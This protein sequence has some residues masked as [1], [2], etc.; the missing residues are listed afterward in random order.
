MMSC[1]FKAMSIVF[2]FGIL[3]HPCFM[4]Y[5]KNVVS[6]LNFLSANNM[7]S[8][9]LEGGP[10]SLQRWRPGCW[11]ACPSGCFAQEHSGPRRGWWRRGCPSPAWYGGV[12]LQSSLPQLLVFLLQFSL[13]SWW[14]APPP[15]LRPDPVGGRW[16]SRACCRWRISTG[17]LFVFL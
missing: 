8:P 1:I 3:E 6:T 14:R 11:A 9:R 5:Q 16:G 2:A 4:L 7:A 15:Y 13:R 17:S 10:H 12:G